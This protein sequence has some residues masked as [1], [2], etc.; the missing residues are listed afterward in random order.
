[1]RC[2]TGEGAF[3]ATVSQAAPCNDVRIRDADESNICF[4]SKTHFWVYSSTPLETM[5][6]H[7]YKQNA[8]YSMGSQLLIIEVRGIFQDRDFG[9]LDGDQIR[10]ALRASHGVNFCLQPPLERLFTDGFAN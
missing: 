3:L 9:F 4:D 5:V 2:P 8:V 6:E 1:M 10:E 7:L